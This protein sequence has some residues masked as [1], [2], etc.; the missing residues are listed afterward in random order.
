M[1][2]SVRRVVASALILISLSGCILSRL[3]DRAFFG[4]T[5]RGG[6]PY[7]QNRVFTGLFIIP[8]AFAVDVVTSPLQ[9]LLMV[10][11]G[12]D[13]LLP[14]K[15]AVSSIALQE[16]LEQNEAFAALDPA[17]RDRLARELEARIASG[18]VQPGVALAL[19]ADGQWI[20]TP[21]DSEARAQ[22]I[23][24]AQLPEQGSA[25]SLGQAVCAR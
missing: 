10:V 24:R 18:Q 25:G 13:F 19:S 2:N 3:T 21:V 14:E 22:L 5:V 12:D 20:D 1:R 11:F 6:K 15:S 23:A 4:M 8:F 17:T 16:R 9:V 7:F